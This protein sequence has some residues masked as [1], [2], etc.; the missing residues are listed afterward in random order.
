MDYAQRLVSL[1]SNAGPQRV[2]YARALAAELDRNGDQSVDGA[3]FQHMFATLLADPARMPEVTGTV[4]TVHKTIFAQTLY[5]SFSRNHAIAAYLAHEALDELDKSGDGEVSVAELDGSWTPPSVTER[6]DALLAKYDTGNKGYI[7]LAD[8]KAAWT[9]DPSLGDASKAQ[10]AIDAFDQNADGQVTHAELV[11]GY[12]AMDRADALLAAFDPQGTG[13]IDLAQATQVPSPDLAAA[14]AQFVHWDSDQDG[15]LTRAELIAGLEA[16]DL[17]AQPS[18]ETPQQPVI[19]SDADPALLAAT[20]LAQYD[21]DRSGSISLDEFKNHVQVS[22]AAATFAA[23]DTQADGELTLDEL[24]T[25]I[26]QVQQAEQIVSQYDTA[27]K[28]WFDASDLEAAIDPA[29]VAD[30]SA[31][32]Q[33]IMS[34]WD[35]NR[36]GKVTVDEVIRGIEAGGYVGGEQLKTD[37]AATPTV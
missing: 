26:A 17:V 2:G 4:S 15:K 33:E 1:L 36:D 21:N 37:A 11:S 22:D 6:A 27:K 14:Q 30:V 8:I 20:L 31:R 13:S 7:D 16:A 35:A 32:A 19:P 5:P 12:Q 24:Q 18:G 25:G 29:S 34:F 9:A 10:A 23:W 3:E 28:G